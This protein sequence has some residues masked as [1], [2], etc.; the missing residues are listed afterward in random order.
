[1]VHYDIVTTYVLPIDAA[2]D[3]IAVKSTRD[4]HE[5]GSIP[6]RREWS[7]DGSGLVTVSSIENSVPGS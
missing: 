3:Y 7:R 4:C 6:Y 1:M 2:E 5:V